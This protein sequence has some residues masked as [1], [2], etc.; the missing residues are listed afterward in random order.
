MNKVFVY[1]TLKKGEP[2]HEELTSRNAQ[3][4]A[5]VVTVEE[6]PLIIASYLNMPFLLYKKEI[7]KVKTIFFLIKLQ[8]FGL[9]YHFSI[10]FFD[11]KI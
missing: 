3:F 9:N 4:L 8:K 7:G 2:N 6:W 1:G 11:N 10:E 5:D